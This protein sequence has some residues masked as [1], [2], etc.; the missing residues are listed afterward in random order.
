M[1]TKIYLHSLRADFADT[2]V[3]SRGEYLGRALQDP[4]SF[5][6]RWLS[7]GCKEPRLVRMRRSFW[8]RLVPLMRLYAC[9]SCRGRVLRRRS[10]PQ[11]LHGTVCIVAPPL[12][13][14]GVRLLRLLAKLPPSAFR[15]ASHPS[16]SAPG[17]TSGLRTT[18]R[19][20]YTAQ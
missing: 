2:Q 15:Q 6:I 8:T 13:S 9:L 11:L 7:C 10:R 1:G 3:L 12:R 20:A 4:R 18:V 14:D 16:A 17:P 19:N 5:P